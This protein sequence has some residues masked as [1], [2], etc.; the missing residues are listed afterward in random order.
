MK[1]FSPCFLLYFSKDVS[2]AVFKCANLSAAICN[3]VLF[4]CRGNFH[5]TFL[6]KF[7][8]VFNISYHVHMFLYLF[9]KQGRVVCFNVYG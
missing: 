5:L 9:G 6:K 4:I 7:P 2:I 1:F 8:W 3:L